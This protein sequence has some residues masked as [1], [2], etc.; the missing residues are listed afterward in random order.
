MSYNYIGDEMKKIVIYSFLIA[1]AAVL[2]LIPASYAADDAN[3]CNTCHSQL[4]DRP[5]E[6]EEREFNSIR[7]KHIEE[8]ISCSLSC[9]V[10][11]FTNMVLSRYDEWRKSK[12]GAKRVTCE[13][14]HGGDETQ[15]I[16]ADAHIGVY[17]SDNP[18]SP[19]NYKNLLKTCGECHLDTI[20]EFENSEHFKQLIESGRGPT[21]STCH[22][23]HSLALPDGDHISEYCSY[24]HNKHT[25]IVPDVSEHASEALDLQSELISKVADAQARVDEGQRLEKDMTELSDRVE[26]SKAILAGSSNMWHEFNLNSFSDQMRGGIKLLEDVETTENTPGIPGFS[27][28]IG[29]FA[30]AM[31]FVFRNIFK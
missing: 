4:G 12:H 22:L 18:K 23:V 21:C 5:P 26:A 19:V 1:L 27:I 7:D 15:E 31:V 16:A 17:G 6:N 20:H 10:D 9:H 3:T 14:C 13:K 29:V 24:C 28:I 30:V 25:N 11:T 2:L 8:D